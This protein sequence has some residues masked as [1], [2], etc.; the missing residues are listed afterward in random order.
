M[1][2]IK[3]IGYG[4]VEPNHLAAQATKEVY[5]QLPANKDITILENGQFAKYDYAKR[6]VNFTGDGEWLMVWNEV[7]HYDPR[8]KALKDFAQIKTDCVD[9]IMVPRLMA[10]KIGD[11]FTTNTLGAN[12]KSNI[13]EVETAATVVKG[14]KLTPGTNGFLKAVSTE[15]SFILKVVEIT[16]LPDGQDAVKLQR[17]A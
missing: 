13:A 9:G 10:I 7:K 1:A 17:I 12:N 2:S 4:Q 5:A 15:T 8:F 3:R 11:I 16:T 6:E 14:D